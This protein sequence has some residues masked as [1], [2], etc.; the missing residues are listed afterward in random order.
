MRNSQRSFNTTAIVLKNI[1]YKDSDKIYTL[2][3]QDRGK[4]SVIGAGVRKI[5]SRRSGSM[6]SFN[7]VSIKASEHESGQLYLSEVV[8]IN[9]FKNLKNNYDS[10][11]HGFYIAE[12]ISKMTK[13]DEHAQEIFQL[14]SE[15]LEKLDIAKENIIVIEN[16]FEIK[17]MQLLGYQP[18]TS[19]LNLWQENM[20]N[21][22]INSANRLIKNFVREMVGEEIKS[23]ELV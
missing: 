12:L 3:S 19:L 6:D 14:V 15:T 20:R 18:P 7:S 4:I 13:E 21:K 1:K 8:L 10:V 23:L 2:Y 17:F 11:K 5:S 9:P 16:R 22:D